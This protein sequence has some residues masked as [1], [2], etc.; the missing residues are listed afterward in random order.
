ME[1]N[2]YQLDIDLVSEDSGFS[3]W[4]FCQK[5]GKEYF[6]KEFLA[7]TYPVDRSKLSEKQVE[8]KIQECKAFEKRL[9]DMYRVI[10]RVSDGN[11]VRIQ[12]FFRCNSKYYIVTD[13]ISYQ[14]LSVNEI[15]KLPYES[16]KMICKVI[17]H[18]LMLLHNEGF[19]H[20]DIKPN[21]VLVIADELR[22]KF[23]AKIIDFDCGFF[24]TEPP[25]P[26]DELNGDPIYFAPEMLLHMMEEDVALSCKID[27]FA[28]GIL[29]H[30]YLSGKQPYFDTG[31]YD[32]V[33]EA[34]LADDRVEIHPEIPTEFAEILKKMLDKEPFRRISLEEV[35]QALSEECLQEFNS[36]NAESVFYRG[37]DL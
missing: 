14:G 20:A 4:G 17:T 5:N 22:S 11:V 7:P 25:N 29:F 3:K 1:I 19:V 32:Y 10:N 23:T 15:A 21:N 16:K 35:Y 30:Q 33:A 26:G 34:V 27:V 6:I 18:S 2:G 8:K 24:G 37:N 9:L 36:W 12:D 13:K 31:K 28:L